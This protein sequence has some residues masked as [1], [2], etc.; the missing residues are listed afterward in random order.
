MTGPIDQESVKHNSDK[1][2]WSILRCVQH[3]RAA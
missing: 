1:A 3:P 2:F